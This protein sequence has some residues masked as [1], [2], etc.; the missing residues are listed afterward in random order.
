MFYW[1]IIWKLL[2]SSVTITRPMDECLERSCTQPLKLTTSALLFLWIITS[3]RVKRSQQIAQTWNSYDIKYPTKYYIPL[4][5]IIFKMFNFSFFAG[6][7][8][9]FLPFCMFL[10]LKP[11]FFYSCFLFSSVPMLPELFH[12]FSLK[13]PQ[14]SDIATAVP[15]NLMSVIL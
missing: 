2:F 4:I 6:T 12:N 11:A 9:T 13:I 15:G 8:L 1:L 10:F 3:Y 5:K 7:C 14:S